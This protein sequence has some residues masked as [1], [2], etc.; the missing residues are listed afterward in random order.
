MGIELLISRR[1]ICFFIEEGSTSQTTQVWYRSY[2]SEGYTHCTSNNWG[3][4]MRQ[5]PRLWKLEPGNQTTR[6]L[7]LRFALCPDEGSVANV[8][9]NSPNSKQLY[10]IKAIGDWSGQPK[11]EGVHRPTTSGQSNADIARH[12][13][14]PLR[15][16]LRSRLGCFRFDFAGW[17]PSSF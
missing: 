5:R 6:Q 3:R 15:S 1:C 9:I 13:R 10:Y 8:A 12:H 2:G 7:D 16:Q 14:P 11:S 17:R 4:P